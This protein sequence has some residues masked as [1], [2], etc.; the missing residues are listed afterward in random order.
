MPSAPR[1]QEGSHVTDTHPG[2][3]RAAAGHRRRTCD[4]A[5]AAVAPHPPFSR[6]MRTSPCSRHAHQPTLRAHSRPSCRRGPGSAPMVAAGR[7]R[8]RPRA[9]TGATPQGVAAMT[10][11][12]DATRQELGDEQAR[13]FRAGIGCSGGRVFH[14]RGRVLPQRDCTRP[15]P[16][17][18]RVGAVQ[19]TPEPHRHGAAACHA[20][21]IPRDVEIATDVTPSTGRTDRPR[22]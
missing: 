5:G 14:E 19:A 2:S 6:S 10:D 22:P 20:R 8:R 11:C 9:C 7:E 12:V 3:P 1:R 15:E 21:R 13:G 18:S 16:S 17:A 4:A